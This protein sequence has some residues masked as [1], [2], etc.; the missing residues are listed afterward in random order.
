MKSPSFRSLLLLAALVSLLASACGSGSGF[1]DEDDVCEALVSALGDNDPTRLVALLPDEEAL[2]LLTLARAWETTESGATRVADEKIRRFVLDQVALEW[3]AQASDRAA[4]RA[5]L[6]R[7]LALALD[8]TR[9]LLGGNPRRRDLKFRR[10]RD[11]A[12]PDTFGDRELAEAE[13]RNGILRFRY[14][15]EQ[16]YVCRVGVAEVNRRWFL[17]SFDAC[18]QATP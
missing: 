18:T 11:D 6:S 10:F 16:E 5:R 17:L 14:Q 2:R 12:N 3:A 15:G 13:I 1:R 4:E 9:D 7:E 8:R